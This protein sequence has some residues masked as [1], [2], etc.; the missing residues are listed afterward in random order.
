MLK[1]KVKVGKVTNLSE[2]R[3]CAGM[4]VDYLS[5]PV[6]N[7]DPK[8]YMEI[9]SWVAGPNFGIEVNREAQDLINQYPC[10]FIQTTLEN[11]NNIPS[12]KKMI[13]ALG[14]KD[15]TNEKTKL[16]QI[17]NRILFLEIDLGTHEASSE[18][19]IKEIA[20]EFDVLVKLTAP[21]EVDQILK[22][23]VAGLSLEGS[24]EVRVGLKEYPLAEVLEKLEE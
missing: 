15:W 8:T 16:I 12:D 20:K 10:E 24:S 2:A 17:K 14:L 22:W 4:G 6:A 13:L 23:P 3:Y 11:L 18:S 1:T 21:N 5:F 7:V 9:T 19:L